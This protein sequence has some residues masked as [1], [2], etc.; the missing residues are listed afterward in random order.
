MSSENP[1]STPGVDRVVLRTINGQPFGLRRPSRADEGEI[2]RRFARKVART[3]GAT[4]SDVLNVYDGNALLWEARLEVLL[5][6]RLGRRGDE[7]NLGETA[8]TGWI[9][10]LHSP[11]G[12]TIGRIIS[13]DAVMPDEFAAVTREFAEVF[14]PKKDPGSGRST[15]PAASPTQG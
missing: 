5:L 2:W 11:E 14:A 7:I 1:N 10:M 15:E 4:E 6:P 3:G 8:P 13:F 9:E 12:A